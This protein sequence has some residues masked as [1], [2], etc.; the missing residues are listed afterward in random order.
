MKKYTPAF[1]SKSVK[2]RDI[3]LQG[4]YTMHDTFYMRVS[5]PRATYTDP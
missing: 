1:T 2:H 4:V 5:N 3:V